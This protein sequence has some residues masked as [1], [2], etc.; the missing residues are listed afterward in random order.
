M[1]LF[2]KS[3]KKKREDKFIVDAEGIKRRG[4]VRDEDDVSQAINRGVRPRFGSFGDF[5]D[6]EE[7]L[8]FKKDWFPVVEERSEKK[9]SKKEKLKES[10][11]FDYSP[12]PIVTEGLSSVKSLPLTYSNRLSLKEEL[13]MQPVNNYALAADVLR[14]LAKTTAQGNKEIAQMSETDV[15]NS[16]LEDISNFL[17]VPF[18][19]D[20][21]C[22]H[23]SNV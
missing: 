23:V 13:G 18:A 9:N 2:K 1:R 12:S 6:A 10:Y 20:G 11:T 17:T 15:V 19:Y 4:I 5:S 3:S 16:L 21:K 7:R 8:Y 22:F 14:A